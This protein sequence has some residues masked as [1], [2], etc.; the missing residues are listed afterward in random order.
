MFVAPPAM[1]V[2][3]DLSATQTRDRER[4]SGSHSKGAERPSK[5]MDELYLAESTE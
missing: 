4:W 3:E 2:D 1:V 5:D